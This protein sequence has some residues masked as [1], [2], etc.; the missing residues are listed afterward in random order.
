MEDAQAAIEA[1]DYARVKF[2][3][4][5]QD[6]AGGFSRGSGAFGTSGS[7]DS[8]KS[9][10]DNEGRGG[11]GR[12]GRGGR[13]GP[14]GGGMGGSFSTRGGGSPG[15]GRGGVRGGRGGSSSSARD[16]SSDKQEWPDKP[17]QHEAGW[18]N[19][20]PAPAVPSEEHKSFAT[21]STPATLS[22]SQ[23]PASGSTST[24]GDSQGST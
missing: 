1:I 12:G 7:Y 4:E 2:G 14:R 6:R 10:S 11:F 9:G 19:E 23:P 16:V 20:E 8:R 22:A 21:S 17:A 24:V 5:Y 3:E 18:P 15:M 13:G